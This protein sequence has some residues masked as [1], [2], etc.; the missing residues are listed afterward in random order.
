MKYNIYEVCILSFISYLWYGLAGKQK[1]GSN[2]FL[3]W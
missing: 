2:D 3:E 1:E